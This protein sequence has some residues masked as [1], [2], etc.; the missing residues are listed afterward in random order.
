MNQPIIIKRQKDK[1]NFT[2][3]KSNNVLLFYIKKISENKKRIL[4]ELILPLFVTLLIVAIYMF[5][6]QES[7]LSRVTTLNSITITV[8]AIQIGF[9]ITSLALIASFGVDTGKLAFKSQEAEEKIFD[10]MKEIINSFG[11]NIVIYMNL[12]GL[13]FL[14]LIL[15]EPVGSNILRKII[16]SLLYLKLIKGFYLTLFIFLIIHGNILFLRNIYLIRLY[17]LSIFKLPK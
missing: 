7:I 5:F 10:F 4:T 3:N 2:H 11:Y 9:L 13:S 1:S 8:V 14:H 16:T 15:I 12:L 17:L 6:Y